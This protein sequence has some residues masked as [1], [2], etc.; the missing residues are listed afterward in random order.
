MKIKL[1]YP[2][3]CLQSMALFPSILGKHDELGQDFS[4]SD[5][6]QILETKLLL[7]FKTKSKCSRFNIEITE[8]Y[9]IG[10]TAIGLLFI[11]K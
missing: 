6:K 7:P 4:S 10:R 5:W 1:N 9:T 3:I 8:M 11:F 2:D